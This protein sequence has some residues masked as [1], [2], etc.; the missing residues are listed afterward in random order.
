MHH[1]FPQRAH[2]R[3]T[4]CR[5][6]RPTCPSWRAIRP[7]AVTGRSR[8]LPETVPLTL[9]ASKRYSSP[10][11]TVRAN[12]S[13]T[14]SS[15][16]GAWL[17]TFRSTPSTATIKSSPRTPNLA[18]PPRR[19]CGSGN[20]LDRNAAHLGTANAVVNGEQ[21]DP[22]DAPFGDVL[23]PTQNDSGRVAF[24]GVNSLPNAGQNRTALA[25]SA[26]G[27][28][29]TST[30]P[31][32]CPAYLS[33]GAAITSRPQI[34]NNGHVV[35]KTQSNAQDQTDPAR[36]RCLTRRLPRRLRIP[37]H[38][39]WSPMC[40]GIPCRRRR[41]RHHPDGKVVVFAG[42]R[43]NGRGSWSVD[44]GLGTPKLVL[45]AGEN[46]TLSPELGS[47]TSG[48]PIYLTF[49]DTQNPTQGVQLDNRV[50]VVHSAAQPTAPRA[51]RV[52]CL[53][54]WLA[55]VEADPA[56]TF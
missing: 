52:R 39:P 45:V 30:N 56:G 41:T 29:C 26:N 14:S 4:T 3:S 35:V 40:H 12:R 15:L 44:D 22:V 9:P 54:H 36:F 46:N 6:S 20:G 47:D 7:V 10:T 2:R 50:S 28:N 13:P 48:N 49:T 53:V 33:V 31:G 25:A 16:V 43:G 34:A 18:A 8:S 32:G 1:A 23:R 11:P 19:L 21:V 17:T 27:G 24:L 37:S 55:G 51:R 38:Y 5:L 42:D